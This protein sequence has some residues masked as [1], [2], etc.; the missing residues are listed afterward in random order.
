MTFF[1]TKLRLHPIGRSTLLPSFIHNKAVV[2]LECDQKSGVPYNDNLC[3]FRCLAVHNGCHTENLSRDTK[4]YF[5]RYVQNRSSP[6]PFCGV[7]LQELPELEK[8]FEVN[9]FVYTLEKAEADGEC[10]DSSSQD[11]TNYHD[12]SNVQITARLLQRS[13]SKYNNTMYLNLYEDHFSYITNINQYSKSF[14]CS[15]C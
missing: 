1:V 5:E 9:I 2:S 13:H 10:N 14:S 11:N 7:T 6:R 12:P 3:F 4:H 8:L 15:R